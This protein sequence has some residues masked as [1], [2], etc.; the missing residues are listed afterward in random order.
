[1]RKRNRFRNYLTF[2]ALVILLVIAA[3]RFIPDKKAASVVTS[4]LFIGTSVAI[5]WR[6]TRFPDYRKRASFWGV[7]FFLLVSALP[8]FA[9]RLIYW[10]MSFE[11]ISLAGVSGADMHRAS[12]YVFI[13]MMVCFF[14]DSYL[15]Q[16]KERQQLQ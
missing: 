9:L 12:S 7:L 5:L 3:F 8:I 14:I 15:E 2:Q 16:V 13:L 1:M 11:E 4:L 10:D 6:E